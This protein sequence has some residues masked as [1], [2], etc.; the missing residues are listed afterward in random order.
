LSEYD[1][2]AKGYRRRVWDVIFLAT[3]NASS[4]NSVLIDAGCGPGHNSAALLQRGFFTSAVC[5]DISFQMIRRALTE[6]TGVEGLLHGL[7]SDMSFMPIREGAADA[8][9][10]IS[11]LHHLVNRAS[12]L[13]ALHEAFKTLRDGGVLLV[14]VWARWQAKLLPL[15]LKGIADYALRRSESPWDI[16][17]CS[18][19][20]TVCREYH[21]YSLGELISDVREAG[22]DVVEVGTYVAP[23]RRSLPRK[24]YY[25]VGVKPRAN[26][27]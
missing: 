9:M 26:S 19:G 22:F 4:H 17:K 21:L 11:S 27:K 1:L 14:V 6:V 5:L 18:K 15:L 23:G 3:R 8:V 20:G 2:I 16:V 10:F 24:N 7:C 25:V 13:R 12:R